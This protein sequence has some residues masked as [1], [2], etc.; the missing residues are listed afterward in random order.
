MRRNFD[1]ADIGQFRH[2]RRR[3]LGPV[4]TVITRHMHTPVIGRTPDFPT[5]MRVFHDRRQA[6][7]GFGAGTV[8]RQGPTGI[9]L[10]AAVVPAEVRRDTF[11][12]VSFIARPEQMVAAGI[13]GAAVM[14]RKADRECP[15]KPVAQIARRKAGCFLWPDIHQLNLTRPPVIALQRTIA[16]RG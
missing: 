15:C 5:T 12:A 16:A 6:G 3:D 8:T 9:I 14:R 10:L 2:I 4:G 13:K 1:G 7:I 11:P